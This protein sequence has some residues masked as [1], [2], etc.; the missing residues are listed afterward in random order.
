LLV[1]T[2]Y[3]TFMKLVLTIHLIRIA[4]ITIWRYSQD[5]YVQ[6][7]LNYMPLFSLLWI[8]NIKRRI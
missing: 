8:E 1:T 3:N 7:Y 6:V 5:R 2:L 4:S